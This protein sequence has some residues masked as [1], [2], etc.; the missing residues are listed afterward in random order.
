MADK[1]A[2]LATFRE[3]ATEPLAYARQWKETH[4]KPVI[5]ILPMNFPAE[6]AHA[7]DAL[8]M[9]LQSDE[10]PITVGLS[11]IFNFYCGYNRSLVDQTLR[12]EFN[13][14]D[15]I[16]L[17]DHCVQLLGTADVIRNQMPEVP[18]LYD[19]LV[20]T[21]NSPWAFEESRRCVGSLKQQLEGV[22]GME[23]S[24]EA[25]NRSIGIFN[26]NRQLLRRLY[27]MRRAGQV[28]LTATEM[29]HIVK[30]SMVMDKEEHSALLE[31]FL[32]SVGGH[33]KAAT[34]RV[35]LYLSG[36]MCHAPKPE[37]LDM[38]EAC[39]GVIVA[40]DLYTGYRY[41]STDVEPA[42]DPL[43]ALTQW[44]LDRNKRV[45][46][47]TRSA[48]GENWDQFLVEAVKA[49]GAQ[50]MIVLLVKF[51]EPHMYYYPDIKETFEKHGIP[52][53]MIETEHEG[54]AMEGLKTR[55]ETFMEVTRRRAQ[56]N[57]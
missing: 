1:S 57:R 52:L 11:R 47:P 22:L 34:D 29:Q 10:E 30:A 2:I 37:I 12:A 3:A 15:A 16:M 54:V 35:P 23:I 33:E 49:S 5:G 53:Y 6:L 55:L 26:H 20:S 38:I 9:L 40:D 48:R 39:G 50:G 36:H 21:I 45:P 19:Q 4:Q 28:T 8:P 31:A 44:Y 13:F 7:A 41:I 56:I 43:D 46:C 18:L 27:E 42:A 24:A 17:G 14:L 25:I 51:C 32:D